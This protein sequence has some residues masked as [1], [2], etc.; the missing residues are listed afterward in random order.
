V[1]APLDGRSS[2]AFADRPWLDVTIESAHVWGCMARL[3]SCASRFGAQPEPL[4]RVAYDLV[5]LL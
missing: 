4:P 2:D 1:V 3:V 5:A